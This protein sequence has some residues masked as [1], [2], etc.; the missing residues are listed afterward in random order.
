M[1]SPVWCR[2]PSA[3]AARIVSATGPAARGVAAGEAVGQAVDEQERYDYRAQIPIAVV[4]A[5]IA[6]AAATAEAAAQAVAGKQEQDDNPPPVV[7]VAKREYYLSSFSCPGHCYDILL[8]RF[9]ICDLSPAVIGVIIF[10]F[11]INREESYH[12]ALLDG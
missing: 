8:R 9:S 5:V 11:R 10:L 2:A 7:T 3:A 1:R 12:D 4:A 6:A